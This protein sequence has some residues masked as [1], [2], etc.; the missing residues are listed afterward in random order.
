MKERPK[1]KGA[2][3]RFNGYLRTADKITALFMALAVCVGLFTMTAGAADPPGGSTEVNT[4][5]GG[6]DMTIS[7]FSELISGTFSDNVAQSINHKGATQLFMQTVDKDDSDGSDIK[8]NQFSLGT[9][10]NVLGYP[11]ERDET[12]N[13]SNIW[14]D[15]SDASSN[16]MTLQSIWDLHA[17]DRNVLTSGELKNEMKIS[18]IAQ[19][20]VWGSALNYMGVDEFRDAKA[21][22]DGVRMMAGYAAYVFFILAYSANNIMAKT[23]EMVRKMNV[24]NW[25]WNGL[26]GGVTEGLKALLGT[27]D[28]RSIVLIDQIMEALEQ[29]MRL[30]WVILGLIVVLFVASLTVF[31]TA[32]YNKAVVAQQRGRR[33][34]YR[35]I[36]MCIGIPLCGAFYTEGLD[37]IGKYTEDSSSDI[38]KY[39]FQEFMDFE[40]WTTGLTYPNNMLRSFKT[41]GTDDPYSKITVTY[42]SSGQRFIITSGDDDDSIDVSRF[43]YSVNEAAYGTNVTGKASDVGYVRGLFGTPEGDETVPS[44]SSIV[45]GE[46][47]DGAKRDTN[48]DKAN[49]YKRCR[50]LLLNYARSNTVMPDVLNNYYVADMN[51]V[52]SSLISVDGSGSETAANEA[53]AA[54]A[55]VLEQLFGVNAAEQRIWSFVDLKDEWIYPATNSAK[56]LTLLDSAVNGSDEKIGVSLRGLAA[57]SS[58]Q[59]MSDDANGVYITRNGGGAKVIMCGVLAN[60]K[61]GVIS[62]RYIDAEGSFISCDAG[63]GNVEVKSNTSSTTGNVNNYTYTYKYDLSKGGMS[64]LSMYNYMHSK[65]ENGTLTVYSPKLTTNAGVGMMHYAV[66]TPYSGIP[67]LVQLL[68]TI[69]ILFSLGIIGWVFGISLLVNSIVQMCKALPT[70]FKMMMGSMQGFAEG[71]LIVFSVLL[72]M[73]VTIALYCLSVHII[74]FLIRLIRGMCTFI[75]EAFGKVNAGDMEYIDPETYAIVAGLL[76][77]AVILWGTFNLLKWRVAITISLKS[78]VTKMVNAVLG[79]NAAMPTGADNKMLKAAAGLAAAGMAAGALAED[80]T[81]DDVVNDLTQSDLG[82][83]LHDKISEGDWDGAMQDIKDYADGTYVSGDGDIDRGEN[84][85]NKAEEMFGKGANGLDDPFGMQSLT[86]EQQQELD[87]KYKDSA[88]AAAD[89]LDKAREAGDQAGIDE[90]QSELNGIL[91][92]RAADAA[93]MRAENGEK[94]RELGVPDYGEHLRA[95][96]AEAEAN[97]LKPVEGA[98][99]PDEPEKELTSDAQ[100]AYD[101]ARDGDAET[102]RSAAGIYDAN[103]LTEEQQQELNDMIADG[104]TE[105]Q[106]AERV[107]QMAEENFGENHAAVVDKMNEAAGRSGGALYGSSDNSEGKARTMAV[108]SGHAEDGSRAYGVRDNS[109]DEGVKTFTTNAEGG[110]DQ[111]FASELPED[112]GQ[113]LSAENQEI[114][115]AAVSGDQAALEEAAQTLDENG[116]TEA[117]AAR[118]DDMV[119]SG[120]SAADIAAQVDDYANGN[121]GANH[122][123]VMERVNAAAGRD[124]T[125][126]YGKGMDPDDRSVSVRAKAGSM[127]GQGSDWGVTDSAAAAAGE[128][129]SESTFQADGKG[130]VAELPTGISDVPSKDLMAGNQAIFEAARDGDTAALRQAADTVNAHGLTAEQEQAVNSMI[131]T[132]A[133]EAEVAAAIDNFAQDNF[134]ND[135]KQ[136]VDSVNAAAGRDG[137]V[138]YGAATGGGEDGMQPRSLEVG[139]GYANGQAAYSVDDLGTEEGAHLIQASDE[140][141]QSVYKDTMPTAGGEQI[142]TSDFGAM[143]GQTYGSIRNEVD[144]VANASGGMLQRGSGSGDF[145][146]TTVSE[147]ASEIASRQS[148][149]ASGGRASAK[150]GSG[151]IGAG[152]ADIGAFNAASKEAVKATGLEPGQAAGISG[153]VDGHGGAV[154]TLPTAEEMAAR[155]G[156]VQTDLRGNPVVNAD[157]G[158][159]QAQLIAAPSVDSYGRGQEAM[160]QAL[161]VETASPSAGTASVSGG[162]P[163][164][165]SGVPGGVTDIPGGIPANVA[166]VAPTG[167]PGGA[168]D[169]P[170]G[171]PAGVPGAV[172]QTGPGGASDVLADIPTASNIP[173]PSA[174]AAAGGAEPMYYDASGNR[175]TMSEAKD[176][177]R[178]FTDAAGRQVDPG[179]VYA[180]G[181][182]SSIASGGPMMYTPG[183]AALS[184]T[185]NADGS[186]TMTDPSGAKVPAKMAISAAKDDGVTF[187]DAAGGALTAVSTPEGNLGFVNSKGEPVSASQAFVSAPADHAA[188]LDAAGASGSVKPAADIP[189]MAPGS[190]PADPGTPYYDMSGNPVTATASGTFQDASGNAVGAGSVY[191]SMPVASSGSGGGAQMYT[192]QDVPVTGTVN[193]DGTVTLRDGSGG[194]VQAQDVIP[195]ASGDGIRFHDGQGNTVRAVS[196][197]NGT[198]SFVDGKGAGVPADQVFASAPVDHQAAQNAVQSAVSA[199]T[200]GASG[201]F[202]VHSGDVQVS[203]N[204][205]VSP[206]GIPVAAPAADYANGGTGAVSG[207]VQGADIPAP[208]GSVDAGMPAAAQ[209]VAGEQPSG[210]FSKADIPMALGVAAAATTFVKTGNLGSAAMAYSGT[211]N[212]AGDIMTRVSGEPGQV[213]A[214]AAPQNVQA[215]PSGGGTVQYGTRPS[216]GA[217]QDVQAPSSGG[218]TVTYRESAPAGGA[219]P[220]VNMPGAAAVN[221][222]TVGT[223]S[224]GSMMVAR[225]GDGVIRTV[226]QAGN[227]T[228]QAVAMTSG[229]K[230]QT[231]TQTP[232]GGFKTSGTGQ[233]AVRMTDGSYVVAAPDGN[234]NLTMADD[235]GGSSGTVL[236]RTAQGYTPA[237]KGNNGV[238]YTIGQDGQATGSVSVESADG[239]GGMSVVRGGDNSIRLA[240]QDGSAS[241]TRVAALAGG[242]YAEIGSDGKASVGGGSRIDVVRTVDGS[243]AGVVTGRDGG[244]Y[245]AGKGGVPSIVPMA[246]FAD[247]T[248][249]TVNAAN[250]SATSS[251]T[252]VHVIRLDDGSRACVAQGSDGNWYRAN[253]DGS[254]SAQAVTPSGDGGWSAGNYTAGPRDAGAATVRETIRETVHETV[255]ETQQGTA[256]DYGALFAPIQ[257]GYNGGQAP[258]MP[259]QMPSDAA[260]SG[261]LGANALWQMQMAQYMSQPGTDAPKQDGQGAAPAGYTPEVFVPDQNAGGG[262]P[263][264]DWDNGGNYIGNSDRG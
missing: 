109:S 85:E 28:L 149:A 84:V 55:T 126:A 56:N 101:A 138:T 198:M 163:T 106:V 192:S 127:A 12:S 263:T 214:G 230:Y 174:G 202:Q 232:D 182:I 221:T 100:M 257:F 51:R 104:A 256:P 2:L 47:P 156:S 128:M 116:L 27:D 185:V 6:I 9:I 242:T 8:K 123:A 142:V 105:G 167:V 233:P 130:G 99:I 95:Q 58:I 120:A 83:S 66:T 71:L 97:G 82:T 125:A 133:S 135:Y 239:T 86:D 194:M 20:I 108:A 173:A 112:P 189:A 1:K 154:N 78:A 219:A 158:D 23:V 213:P 234:G 241:G 246:S 144:A 184:G 253:R 157:A 53:A 203:P 223:A 179:S 54:N 240:N 111:Q 218:G 170:G 159:G 161:G 145:G 34:V 235:G 96:K 26:K 139:S 69:S 165:V 237:V 152:Q 236:T 38:T 60:S 68:F 243:H 244:V 121:L 48:A 73:L 35:L 205:S 201:G 228:N 30:R 87:D 44:Y 36:I 31:K 252:A 75:L 245:M 7:R 119:D 190:V 65:F 10:G 13:A 162:I 29:F 37:V 146:R 143:D 98:D 118:I 93:E 18:P 200:P 166:G 39:V 11:G 258:M 21:A 67:E 79:T 215:A 255:T 169:I 224:G 14:T 183:D 260:Q 250:M 76:S 64:P 225:G 226:D 197:A 168:M 210:G 94:A 207:T 188:A 81:L 102:L 63:A 129:P 115:D 19:Y 259:W 141:G 212:A 25:I 238:S 17:G 187:H 220:A 46:L 91:Q 195:A 110:L 181:S 59:T 15:G 199:V 132:G 134:G 57:A 70:M 22:P 155:G 77:T 24:F 209:P 80:G 74:D 88:M 208:G 171:V 160:A 43:V 107:E 52:A 45:N 153:G 114:Y 191:S 175:L 113:R 172:S 32:G 90:A 204:G 216:G 261:Q 222:A 72:E 124:N 229:G 164:N 103:G 180:S 254:P 217:A 137:T 247:G 148:R 147:A 231:I 49:A 150:V 136:V 248:Y 16:M 206:N 176:G 42:E 61:S 262:D 227:I 62:N 177:T 264:A 131:S 33:I 122:K 50:D 5:I 117:Q 151:I 89:K 193:K 41:G 92:A 3:R 196:N 4:N 40:A 140:D 211:K 251:G 249:G 178:S 186:M